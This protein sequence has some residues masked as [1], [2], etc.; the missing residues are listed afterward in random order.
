[1]FTTRSKLTAYSTKG[2]TTTDRP[3]NATTG[4]KVSLSKFFQ[5]A[6]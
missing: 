3:V 2:K 6:N 1:M 5:E 4:H